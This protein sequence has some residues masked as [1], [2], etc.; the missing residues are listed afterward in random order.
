MIHSSFTQVPSK[1]LW[2]LSKVTRNVYFLY[3]LGKLP[4]DFLKFLFV[5]FSFSTF[6]SRCEDDDQ[7]YKSCNIPHEYCQRANEPDFQPFFKR[8]PV[9]W[10]SMLRLPAFPLYVSVFSWAICQLM[11][12]GLAKFTLK[13]SA[14]FYFQAIQS[15]FTWH[16]QLFFISYFY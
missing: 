8:I 10:W 9:F 15:K 1:H 6:Q 4:K 14:F 2:I 13:F 16:D 11:W 5:L 12:D 3:G 7:H